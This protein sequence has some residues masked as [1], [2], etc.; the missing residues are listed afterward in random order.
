MHGRIWFST[1]L[2]VFLWRKSK[3]KFLLASMKSLTNS[4]N[5]SRTP[6][7]RV[8]SGFPQP[9]M[10]VNVVPKTACDSNKYSTDY[11][12]LL[13]LQTSDKAHMF[14]RFEGWMLTEAC[15]FYP[16]T[17]YLAKYPPPP[18][19]I[20]SHSKPERRHGSPRVPGHS[21]LAWHSSCRWIV[22]IY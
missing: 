15:T 6:L 1:F 3:I 16:G 18:Q 13:E 10:S 22:Y 4:E 20:F 11:I 17:I 5:S 8:W 2:A 9:P 21:F 19:M 12:I 14:L 7:Q